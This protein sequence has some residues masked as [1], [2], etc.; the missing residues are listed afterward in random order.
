[1]QKRDFNSWFATFKHSISDYKYYI[2]FAKVIKNVNQYKVELNILNSL[3]GEE[4][5]ER[6]FEELVVDYP[7]ALACI[8]I[9][10]AVRAKEISVLDNSELLQYRFDKLN[11]SVAQYKHFMRQTGLFNLLQKHL[12][13]NLCDYVTGVE[14][15]LDSNGRKNRGGHLME[16]LVESYLKEAGLEYY[17]EMY[18]EEITFKWNIDL[19][20]ISNEGKTKKRFDFVIKTDSVVYASETNFY[21]SGGSKLNETARSYK[22]IAEKTRNIPGFEFVWFTDGNG[23]MSA[24]NNLR[25]TFEVLKHLYNIE[26]LRHGIL[27][28]FK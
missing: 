27:T 24:R 20:V 28:S 8:P 17:K 1:M 23:W 5:I 7:K 11:Y 19:S 3:I 21:S 22:L 12:I 15:G 2:D 13:N 4:D 25:E 16:D 9:L 18:L 6:R 26:D 10:L 14:A